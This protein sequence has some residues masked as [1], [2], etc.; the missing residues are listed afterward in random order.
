[1][2]LSACFTE[3]TFP[4]CFPPL[5]HRDDD[6]KTINMRALRD[7]LGFALDDQQFP[8]DK[9]LAPFP[10]LFNEA[11]NADLTLLILNHSF[12]EAKNHF[13]FYKNLVQPSGS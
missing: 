3:H 2:L 10:R 11:F 13:C 8:F 1:M 12:G 6:V 4:F 9:G 7:C 5:T